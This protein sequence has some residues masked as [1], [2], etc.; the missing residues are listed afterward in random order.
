MQATV[1]PEFPLTGASW[2]PEMWPETEWPADLARMR[3]IGF[4]IVRLFEFAWH[5]FEPEEGRYDFAWA[6]RLLDLCHEAG[7]AVMIGTPTAAPPA[8]L[9]TRY[10]EVLQTDAAGRRSTH[11]Q[12][13]HYSVYSAKY[14][15]LC[16]G[17][18]R[19][20]ADELASHPALH[21][22]QIDNEMGG[23]DFSAETQAGFHDWL[24]KRYGTVGTLNETWGLEFW[25]QAYQD[26]AQI[27]MPTASVG[28]IEVPERH[29]PSLILAMARYN[30]DAWSRFIREQCAIIRGKS[31]KPITSNMT[32]GLGMNWF[33]HNRLLDRVGYSIYSDLDHYDWTV[34]RLDR[35]RA[36]KPLP[37][38]V[39]ETAPNWSGGGRQ[40]NIH[41][42]GDGVRAYTWLT[43]I[44]GG[45]M[46]LYW[47][48][49]SHWAGQEMQHGTC[50]SATGRWRPGRESWK[51]ITDERRDHADWMEAHP[52]APAAVGIVLSNESAWG[53]S[54]DPITDD[55][56]YGD[57]WRSDHYLPLVHNH[58]WRD[59]ISP[60]ADISRYQAL[61]LPLLPIVPPALRAQLEPWVRSG[62]H[63]LLGPL[64]GYRTGEWTAFRD[65][66]LGGL[67]DL[68]GGEVST[69][70]SAMWIEQQIR[71]DFGDAEVV[72]PIGFCDGY[73]PDGAT[74]LACYRGGYGD[75]TVAILENRIGRGSVIALGCRVD[76]ATYHRLAQ[77]LFARA[78]IRPLGS[79][80]DEK[81]IVAPRG[82]D[83]LGI[84]N[85]SEQPRTLSLPGSGR[86]RMTG[87]TVGPVVRLDP[88]EV[89][90]VDTGAS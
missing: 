5:R 65:R 8:W 37:Y 46:M 74:P 34:E 79:G 75:G 69:Q 71:L 24:R 17:L 82:R 51:Q 20:M 57:R 6:R 16:A 78:G 23:G 83:G 61:L 39:L 84:V 76:A 64:T 11:G 18:V 62:G 88:L 26:F 40:W 2:Y 58:I 45:S 3:E 30:N 63:L 43:Q 56:R 90:L 9:T 73:R 66:E 85:I 32:A 47:Q 10:P 80:G 42:S 60:D 59:I 15:E 72:H 31:D 89:M 1:P 4:N 50:V 7:I 68:I 77:R 44:L 29:H 67:E 54:I 48:W 36:E 25:S 21:S 49:R 35:M 28:S 52:S 22:W 13:K 33:Q 70:F 87:R 14:R 38:W 86:N 27:P 53:F 12:R 41:H 19:K 55:M 81:V